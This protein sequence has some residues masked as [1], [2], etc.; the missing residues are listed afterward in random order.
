MKVQYSK[1]YRGYSG[2]DEGGVYY[3]HPV[4]EKWLVRKYVVPNNTKNTDRTKAI[5]INLKLLNP[6]DGYKQ[7]FKDYLIGYNKLKENQDSPALSWYNLYIKMLF[8]LQKL[9]A[10]VNLLTLS[11]AQIFAENLPCRTVKAAIDAGLLPATKNY[12][13]LTKD[14]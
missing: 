1:K 10:S 6:S 9:Y 3:Y 7:N 14:I 11:R 13:R 5:M 12:K 2:T 8:A 4:L